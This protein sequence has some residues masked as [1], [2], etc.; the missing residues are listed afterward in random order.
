ML[1]TRA[2]PFLG[3]PMAK[4]LRA[5]LPATDNLIIHDKNTE[6]TSN[7]VKEMGLAASNARAGEKGFNIDIASSVRDVAERSVSP[8]LISCICHVLR[9]PCVSLSL[10]LVMKTISNIPLI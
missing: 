6:A 10:S 5:K 1:T 8:A 3:Y 7:F 9:L 4:N 2:T